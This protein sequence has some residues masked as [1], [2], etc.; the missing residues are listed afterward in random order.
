MGFM[1]SGTHLRTFFKGMAMGMADIVPGVS[2]GT[3]ALILGIYERLVRSIS[4]VKPAALGKTIRRESG[5]ID[6]KLFVPLGAGIAA[7]FLIMSN[8]I[9]FLLND[10]ASPTYA[11]FFTLILGSAIMLI[12]SERVGSPANLAFA[13]VGFGA[14]FWLVG[15]DTASLGHSLPVIFISGLIA[16]TAMILP[17]IS[18]ALILLLLN[19]YEFL[20]DALKSVHLPEIV[21][22]LAGAVMGL[23]AFSRVLNRLL[24]KF[25]GQTVAFLIGL[26]L[27]ALRLCY[28]NMTFD[29]TTIFSIWVAGLIGFCIVFLLEIGRTKSKRTAKR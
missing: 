27:G 2:G 25:R 5:G 7:A 22:F 17:G 11:F 10:L 28:D 15:L 8:I 20:L 9:L 29:S 3:V 23:L 16:I 1:G 21:T 14:S 6:V 4:Q 13:I 19:Q 18:G 24:E 12:R 26:M